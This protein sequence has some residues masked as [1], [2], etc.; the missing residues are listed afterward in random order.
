V[1]SAQALKLLL[2]THIWIWSHLEPNRLARRVRAQI[3]RLPNDLW[4][5]P[6]SV[7][8]FLMLCRKGR[9]APQ[10]GPLNWVTQALAAMPVTEAVL[11]LDIA[12]ETERIDIVSRDP[13]DRFLVATARV[14]DLTLVSADRRIIGTKDCS[15]LPNP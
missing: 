4:L 14:L 6:L 2:D 12:L 13:V 3:E 9:L 5:S 11:T 7:W 10:G 8:E 15:V 1:G